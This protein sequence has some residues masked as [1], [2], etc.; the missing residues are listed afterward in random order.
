[1]LYLEIANWFRCIKLCLIM[2]L[3][4]LSV[5]VINYSEFINHKY[6]D[7]I[8][9]LFLGSAKFHTHSTSS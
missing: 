7:L 4:V 2:T 3:Y 8:L 9:T 6:F 5:C 1:M